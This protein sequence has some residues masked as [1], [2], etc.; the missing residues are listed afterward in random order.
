ME[1]TLNKSSPQRSKV[2]ILFNERKL[3]NI[4]ETLCDTLSVLSSSLTTILHPG[5][6]AQQ[7]YL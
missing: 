1:Y 5:G 4:L 2:V 3:E 7:L 6:R